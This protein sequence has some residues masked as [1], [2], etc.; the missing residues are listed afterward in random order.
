VELSA[1]D[2][3]GSRLRDVVDSVLRCLFW[4]MQGRL[5][6]AVDVVGERAHEVRVSGRGFFSRY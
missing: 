1:S 5:S 6:V 4:V 3:L 2:D